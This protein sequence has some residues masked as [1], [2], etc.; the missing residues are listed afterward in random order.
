MVEYRKLCNGF[1]NLLLL[2]CIMSLGQAADPLTVKTEQVTV[3]GKYLTSRGG[4]SYGAFLG[5]PYAAV[6]ARFEVRN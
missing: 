3:K 5:I 6:P 1:I 4:R 2:L